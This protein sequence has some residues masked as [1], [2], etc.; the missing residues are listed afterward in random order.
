MGIL[1][2]G[3]PGDKVGAGTPWVGTTTR[4]GSSAPQQQGWASASRV[5]PCSG[6][7]LGKETQVS[8]TSVM[9]RLCSSGPG[10]PPGGAD[11][12]PRWQ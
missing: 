10:W 2:L 5:G 8:C 3:H 4:M 9:A 6:T 7:Q 11:A 1:E 12:M